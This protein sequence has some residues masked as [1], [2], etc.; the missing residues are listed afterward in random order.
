[1][2]LLNGADGVT[3]VFSKALTM[4]GTGLGLARQMLASTGDQALRRELPEQNGKAAGP[5]KGTKE[6]VEVAE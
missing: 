2:V 5:G 4:G 1:M 6:T 3:D